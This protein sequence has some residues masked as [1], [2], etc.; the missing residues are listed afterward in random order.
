MTSPEKKRKRKK[1]SLN[2][3]P[4]LPDDLVLSIIARVSRLYYPTLSLV[5]KSFRSM[6]ASPEL[7]K[8]RS[9][10]GRK[11]SCL[12]LCVKMNHSCRWFTLC[13]KPDKTLTSDTSEKKKS[14]SYVLAKVPIPYSPDANFSSL[15]AVGSNI[16]NI[17]I[18]ESR[19]KAFSSTVSVLDCTSH[20]W[21]K[22]P[23]L[24]VEPFTLSASVLDQKIY[25]AGSYIDDDDSKF[26]KNSFEVFDT[27][28]QVWDLESMPHSVVEDKSFTNSACIDENIHVMAGSRLVAYNP[29]EGRW[30]NM[31]PQPA[32]M[33][34]YVCS[35]SR[36]EIDNVSYCFSNGNIKWYDTE[37]RR[38]KIL[39][40]LV[41]LP[42]FSLGGW[43]GLA[44]Y[45][46]KMAVLWEENSIYGCSF[47]YKKLIWCAEI[48]LERRKSCEIRGKVEWFDH[49]LRVSMTSYLGKVLVATV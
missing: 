19:F 13:R 8:A 48:S 45:G 28:T 10:L 14:N 35:Y 2:P 49:L 21:R 46:G 33:S 12:Y 1:Q 7:Y 37:V 15:V 26:L 41:G 5:S 23:S 24:L 6:L 47:L 31:V 30:D 43:V 32:M 34:T 25:V 22:A 29:K 36:C 3:N 42:K 4:S 18:S 9:L 27:R 38:W 11:E 17:G 16:Y 20:T 39:K 40:G 44:D